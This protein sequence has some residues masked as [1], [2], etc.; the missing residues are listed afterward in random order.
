MT[1]ERRPGR[2][3][4]SLDAPRIRALLVA[5]EHGHPLKR[6]CES[7]GIGVSTVHAWIARGE[8]TSEA[9]A[10]GREIDPAE[11]PYSELSDAIKRARVAAQHRSLQVIRDAAEQH[12]TWQAAAWL[13]ERTDPGHYGRRAGPRPEPEE[14]TAADLEAKIERLIE[15]Y[16]A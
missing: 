4:P 16:G 2:P 6:A 12:G 11:L 14:V 15:E 8:R 5:L 1:P 7:A 3:P 10:D 9:I 13:L